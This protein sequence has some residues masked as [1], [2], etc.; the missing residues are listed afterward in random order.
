[1]Y[2]IRSYYESFKAYRAAPDNPDKLYNETLLSMCEGDENE[3]FIGA[4]GA[5]HKMDMTTGKVERY[6]H[7]STNYNSL[8]GNNIY[9][10]VKGDNN[11]IWIGITNSQWGGLDEMDLTVITSYSIH[12]TKLYDV[13]PLWIHR[14]KFRF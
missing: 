13:F 11:N 3:L 2:A 8:S 12:Y 7:D 14:F 10:L 6:F 5:L 9:G 4:F 1:M